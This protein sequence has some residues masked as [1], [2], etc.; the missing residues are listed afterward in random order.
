MSEPPQNV[1]FPITITIHGFANLSAL[2]PPT[3][4]RILEG[5]LVVPQSLVS[6]ELN[7][8]LSPK[9]KEANTANSPAAKTLMFTIRLNGS[10]K[11][12]VLYI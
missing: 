9:N 11:L 2:W 7:P 5:C 3:T 10:L 8:S 1:S 12:N 6:K 4:R